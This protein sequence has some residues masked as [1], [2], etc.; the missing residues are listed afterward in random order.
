VARSIVCHDG[1]ETRGGCSL[2]DE[3]TSCVRIGIVSGHGRV[4][5]K[6][7]VMTH[8]MA[9]TVVSNSTAFFCNAQSV[10]GTN[11]VNKS[12]STIVKELTKRTAISADPLSVAGEDFILAKLKSTSEPF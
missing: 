12:Y 9:K 10:S 1:S 4:V 2:G 11:R 8:L 6:T 5:V 3:M 7:D